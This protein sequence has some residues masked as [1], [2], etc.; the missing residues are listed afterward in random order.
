MR[1][2]I[3]LIYES[4]KL[5]KH[6]IRII[7]IFILFFS[8]FF[9]LGQTYQTFRA[10]ME[11]IVQNA[12]FKI[13]PLKLLPAIRFTNIGYDN[14][15]FNMR[16]EEDPISD[17]TFTFS[18]QIN[19]YLLYRNWVIFSLI[20]N[21][22]Y[23]YF[24]KQKR[25]RRLNNSLSTS[26]RLLLLNHFVI[27][28][29]YLNMN[30][31]RRPTSE[32]DVRANEIIETW[33]TNFFY[34]TDRRTS[35]GLSVSNTKIRYED[36]T[37]PGEEIRFSWALNRSE[38]N[39]RL[40]FYYRIFLDS[41]FH[42][43]AEQTD[44]DFENP[45]SFDKNSYSYQVYSGIQFPLLGRIRGTLSLGYRKFIPKDKQRKGFS[46][47]VGNTDLNLRIGRFNFLLIYNRDIS[48][49]FR[50]TNVF[51][52]WDRYGAG[53]SYYLTRFLRLDYEFTYEEGNYP[54]EFLIIVSD[55]SFERI[56]RRDI[57]N[58]HRT[59]IVFRIVGN[60]GIG[61]GINIWNRE[62][63]ISEANRS[64]V[65]ITGYLTYDF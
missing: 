23:V 43:R 48:F 52:E 49:S 5:S 41:T 38:K 24:F 1:K 2:T 58:M 60:I 15:V 18:P 32:F 17:Y 40:E 53:C 3:S 25:E 14:N 7:F 37:Q 11:Q 9:M 64:R 27:S 33:S 50:R 30:R 16:K 59:G 44:Y 42:V 26:L 56:R 35:I 36:I 12:R 63:T 62:S 57:Y 31:R 28:G 47:V 10:E 19:S 34:E 61:L 13:G 22:E 29:N 39:V 20:E 21:P 55:D 46:G 54:E 51:A 8:P 65:F 4:K 6:I 45:E